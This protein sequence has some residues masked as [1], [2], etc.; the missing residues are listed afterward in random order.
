MELNQN[1]TITT[2]QELDQVL[3]P[4]MMQSLKILQAT[5]Q[6]LE[7]AIMTE[8]VQNPALELVALGREE[9][10]GNPI[11]DSLAKSERDEDREAQLAE[12]DENLV[13][14]VREA[15]DDDAP[16][17][18]YL[19]NPVHPLDAEERHARLIASLTT[20]PTL[21]DKLLEQIHDLIPDAAPEN[22]LYRA[23]LEV[24]GNLNE[25][26][27]LEANAE[28]IALGAEVET[29][30]ATAAI[31]LIQGLEP[32]GL[33]TKDMRECLLAQLDRAR[34]HGSLA[35]EIVNEHLEDLSRNR[36][37]KIAQALDADLEEIQE[38][39]Q[40]IRSLDPKPGLS[41]ASSAAPAIM[42]EVYIERDPDGS[43]TVRRNRTH[44][45]RLRISP[46]YLKL[47][48]NANLPATDRQCIRKYINSGR[49]LIYSIDL[50]QSTIERIAGQIIEFQGDFLEHGTSQL[51]P[52][53]IAQVAERLEL[54]ETTISRAMANKYVMTP[55]GLF[56]FKH[57]FSSGYDSDDGEALSSRAVKMKI[58]AH[59]KQESPTKP[60]SDQKIVELLAEEGIQLARRT[61]AKYREEENIPAA[62]LRRVH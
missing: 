57:F 25:R 54:H 29:S 28:D 5:T 23:C 26:G 38:A 50:R 19:P 51:R 60:L 22:Q 49:Q 33:A 37:P 35:W 4:Q 21:Q 34:E 13:D 52:L 27:Y 6:E 17:D 18:E 15:A 42:P 2:R 8:L 62:S 12:Y 20:E 10:I 59:I 32:A 56:S 61:V 31:K 36:I 46:N 48:E 40:R 1:I 3:T 45:P 11:E 39:A 16:L 55:H 30:V 24:L 9:L 44:L 58:A 41:L 47:Q 53:N 43:W 7:Q 14:A